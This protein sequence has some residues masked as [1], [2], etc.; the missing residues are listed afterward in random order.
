[1]SNRGSTLTFVLALLFWGCTGGQERT[2]VT[3]LLREARQ[4]LAPDRR[5]QVFDVSGE[6]RGN[7][8]IVRGEIHSA[9]LKER[10]IR[11]LTEKRHYTVVDSLV[12]LPA[13]D[14]GGVRAARRHAQRRGVLGAAAR[15]QAV[16]LGLFGGDGVQIQGVAD[17]PGET[18]E[19]NG[20]FPADLEDRSK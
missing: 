5:T 17:L 19:E 13:A 8:L 10:L 12:V 16:E 14:L 2:M 11:F 1:M 3:D 20:R 9:E 7:T 4:Q 6:L 18:A 15:Q